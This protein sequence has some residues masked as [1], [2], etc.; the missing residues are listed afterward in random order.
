MPVRLLPHL[1]GIFMR[2][3]FRIRGMDENPYKAPSDSH[4]SPP[5]RQ[6]P[7][8]LTPREVLGLGLLAI[9]MAVMVFAVNFAIRNW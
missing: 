5:S 9:A 1:A 7:F 6:N 8:R 2:Q 3:G 4:D